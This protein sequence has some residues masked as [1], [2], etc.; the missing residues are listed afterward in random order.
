MR[1]FVEASGFTG[2]SVTFNVPAPLRSASCLEETSVWVGVDGVDDHDLL[3]VGIAE[4]DLV[5]PNTLGPSESPPGSPPFFWVAQSGSLPGG[6]TSRSPG[7]GPPPGRGQR[8]R[9]RCPGPTG[10]R[11]PNR[12]SGALGLCRYVPAQEYNVFVSVP[13]TEVA[14]FLRCLLQR[15]PA[16][17][18]PCTT[19]EFQRSRT[20]PAFRPGL[21]FGWD[22]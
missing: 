4:T 1:G 7:A 6:R 20:V 19:V 2:V 18:N 3:K 14:S 15:L 16:L 11:M 10:R 5:P 13:R 22:Q 12:L 8:Q 9:G 17:R 21:V